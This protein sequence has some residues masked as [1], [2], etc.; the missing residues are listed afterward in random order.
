MS[1]RKK[2]RNKSGSRKQASDQQLKVLLA[3]L[4][5]LGFLVLSLVLLSQMRQ[6]FRPCLSPP[7]ATLGNVL[8]EM[9]STLLPSGAPLNRAWTKDEGNPLCFDIQGD[10]PPP[11]VLDTLSQRLNDISA[12]IRLHT[13]PSEK[14]ICVYHGDTAYF[15]FRFQRS[16]V[17]EPVKKKPRLAIVMDDLGSSIDTA[18]ALLAINVPVTFSILPGEVNTSRIATLAHQHG[19][20]V[21]IHIPMEPR[22]YPATNPGRNALFVNLSPAEIRYKFQGYL[23]DVP[24]AVGGN[25]HMGSRFTEYRKGMA[26]VIEQMKAADLFFLDSLTTGRSVA[27]D[28]ARKAGVPAA[29]RDLFL[30]NTRDVN[31]IYRQIR[32][33]VQLAKKNG[34]AIGI[35]H[36]YPQTLEALRL[37]V[38][39][40]QGKDIEVVP[41]SQLL[42]R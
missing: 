1:S 14:E 6:L 26:V 15:L 4:F 3:A 28:E 41:V 37:Q 20:E 22:S 33:L 16:L 32:K 19:R 36:P 40:L 34:Y 11:G 9:E 30:D 8:A 29:V 12:E 21:M 27:F 31:H 10:F 18:R 23:K 35:C 25:N 2:S 42:V 7:V 5:V 13:R 17:K 24:Y 38:A 39:V